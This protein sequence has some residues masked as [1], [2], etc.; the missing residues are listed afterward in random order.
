MSETKR[1]AVQRAFH[2]VYKTTCLKTGFFYIGMYSADVMD[3]LFLGAGQGIS[4]SISKYG[5]DNHKLDVLAYA[6]SRKELKPLMAS[7]E[8][9]EQ[10][11][12][13][14]KS[15]SRIVPKQTQH[16]DQ[17]QRADQRAFHF[18]YKTTC[19]ITGNYYIGMHSTDKIEDG[20]LGSGQRL[21][22]SIAKHG[23]ENHKREIIGYA[24]SRKE[25]SA[26]EESLVTKEEVAKQEC[27]NLRIGGEGNFPAFEVQPSTKE[28]LSTT[29]TARW[30]RD[31]SSLKQKL[32]EELKNFKLTRKQILEILLTEE[33]RLNK[34]ITRHLAEPVKP[35][36][37][38]F[39]LNRRAAMN[40]AK[41]NFIREAI[42]NSEFG[43][44]P[45]E[46]INAYV[47][48]L[49]KR[50]V[51]KTCSSSVSFFRFNQPYAMYCSNRCQ[52]LDPNFKNP[53]LSRWESLRKT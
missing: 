5:T 23:K 19:S 34:N 30:T 20:Y 43:D 48:K 46:L 32:E 28:K 13:L 35:Q 41:W 14:R 1:R 16:G 9:R 33:G 7:I 8:A 39:K 6:S 52:L 36:A 27:M 42:Q 11:P 25:L 17:K 47:F 15:Y 53:V 24:K 38:E 4:K 50:P 18:V 12:K 44:D 37:H 29:G 26:L 40:T 31:R 21:W 2:F 45:V 10:T 49:K 3:D 51:C 22:K